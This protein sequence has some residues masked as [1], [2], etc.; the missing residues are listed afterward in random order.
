MIYKNGNLLLIQVSWVYS[1]LL[2]DNQKIL[3]ISD[4]I[5]EF[6]LGKHSK[7]SLREELLGK[8]NMS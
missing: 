7:H 1:L 6:V 8:I 3:N 5:N 2:V 4:F